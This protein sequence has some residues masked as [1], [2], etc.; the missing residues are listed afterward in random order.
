MPSFARRPSALA[1][2]FASLSLL[3]VPAC[4]SSDGAN[5]APRDGDAGVESGGDA[6]V[7]SNDVIVRF[8]NRWGHADNAPVEKANRYGTHSPTIVASVDGKETTFEPT[9]RDDGAFVFTGVPRAPYVLEAR[10]KRTAAPAEDPVYLVRYP[11]DGRRNLEMGEDYWGRADATAM[12]DDTKLALTVQAPKGIA[13]GDSFSWLG[14]HSY[15]Y[16]AVTFYDGDVVEGIQNPPTGDATSSQDWTFDSTVLEMPYGDDASGLP[17]AAANDDLLILQDRTERKK[18]PIDPADPL[19]RFAP[20]SS[21]NSNTVIGV[22][23]AASPDFANGKTNT[24]TGT[25]EAPKTERFTIDFHGGTFDAVRLAIGAPDETRSFARIS[26]SQE[27]GAGPAVYTSV[28]PEAWSLSASAQRT[29]VDLSC[30]P[31]PESTTC[32]PDACAIGCENARKGHL[33]P[34]ELSKFAFEGPRVFETG[35]RDFYSVSYTYYT[36]VK[37]PDASSRTLSGG[38][39]NSFPR[40]TSEPSFGLELGPPSAITVNGNA[41]VWDGTIASIPDDR[42]PVVAFTPATEGAPEHHRVEVIDLTPDLGNE[43]EAPRPSL[44]VALLYTHD[45]SVSIPTDVLRSGHTYYVRVAAIKDGWKFG[46]RA[47]RSW[48]YR[49]GIYSAPFVFGMA[50]PPAEQ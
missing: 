31:N 20:W 38:V 39:S 14:L 43:I 48:M 29:P 17:S 12:T 11:I 25:L 34:G 7:E 9:V 37:L 28:A 27:A 41:L 40:T 10:L 32:V 15:F 42:A 44:T 1:S 36:D 13:D 16:R 18:M 5:G 33:H 3:L 2:L 8:V 24:V 19:A 46:E 50:L 30:F 6:G 26:L 21:F 23:H 35:M 49:T 22:L 4:S 45:A 47:T